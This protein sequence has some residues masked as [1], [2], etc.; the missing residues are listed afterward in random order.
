MTNNLNCLCATTPDPASLNIIKTYEEDSHYSRRLVQCPICKQLFFKE[1]TEEIDWIDG[2]DPQFTVLIPVADTETSD[3]AILAKT[4]P[5]G[6]RFIIDWPKDGPR[7]MYWQGREDDNL[8]YTDLTKIIQPYLE[9]GTSGDHPTFTIIMGPVGSGK[10]RLIKETYGAGNVL[11]DAGRLYLDLTENETKAFE[12]VHGIVLFLGK[13]LLN[14]SIRTKKNILIEI[15]SG[16]VES[17][18]AI[19]D[20]MKSNGY[21]N[22]ILFIDNS[23]E[24][25]WKNNLSRSVNNISAHYSQG[26][27]IGI[28]L[29]HFSKPWRENAASLVK[30]RISGDRKGLPGVPAWGHSFRVSEILRHDGFDHETSVAGLLH[31]IIED[32]GVTSKE[33]ELAEFSKRTIDLVKLCTHDSTIENKDRRWLIMMGKLAQ[34][35]DP[36]AWAIKTA[37]LLDNVRDSAGLSADRKTFMLEVKA[38]LMLASTVDVPGISELRA[39]LEAAVNGCKMK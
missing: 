36:N 29:E 34:T 20:K 18:E 16:T 30:E 8:R 28:F 19:A 6:P 1:F 3:A 2:E 24:N 17:I 5:S 12:D 21:E 38:P 25:S 11:I 10:S 39:E 31:D 9:N 22:K 4:Q 15:T 26:E 35:N 37:D 27:T 23:I 32:G 7:K 14:E 33:L 13:Y